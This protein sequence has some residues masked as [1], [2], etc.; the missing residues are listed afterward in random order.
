MAK[1]HRR[2]AA[3]HR[4]P[5]L[6]PNRGPR[7]SGAAPGASARALQPAALANRPLADACPPLTAHRSHPDTKARCAAMMTRPYK[8][9]GPNPVGTADRMQ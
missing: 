7:G 1:S 5:H 4:G 3:S 6:D 2:A 9:Q 8:D